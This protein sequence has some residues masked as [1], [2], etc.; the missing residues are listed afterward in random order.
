MSKLSK[1]NDTGKKRILSSIPF[2]K[3]L[4]KN[5]DNI[6]RAKKKNNEPNKN[7]SSLDKE[8]SSALEHLQEFVIGQDD[9]IKGVCRAF[10]RPF[11]IDNGKTYANLVFVFGPKGSGRYYA[12]KVIAV[13]LKNRRLLKTADIYNLDFSIYDSDEHTNKLLLP[14]LYKAFYGKP[15]VV[16]IND[17]DKACRKA[18]AY[19][20]SLVE[21]G[22][23]KV[24]KRF[25]WN[26]GD[27]QEVSGSY[28][29]GT[30]NALSA[31]GK[32]IFVLSEKSQDYLYQVFPKSFTSEIQD[33][34]H[35]N[36]LS[37]DYLEE[38]GD[39]FFCDLSE[40]LKANFEIV[41][42][43]RF[44]T[45]DILT[46]GII[47]N[48]AE[49]LND[50]INKKTYNAIGNM[51]LINQ[52]ERGSKLSLSIS[53]NKIY[54][55]GLYLIDIG[56]S[57]D[58]DAVNLAKEE[59]NKIIG[60]E[61]VKAFL[62]DIELQIR[63]DI[64]SGKN[65]EIS[66]H[67][68]FTGNPGTGKTS[69]ARIVAKWFKALGFLSSGHLIESS[70]SDFVGQY[71]GET[72]IK[73]L[74]VLKRAKG[75]ILFIDEAYSLSLGKGDSFG[76]EA[77]DT[78]VKYMEDNRDDL[79]IILAGYSK[80]MDEF[81]KI[82]SG[83]KSRF[84]YSIEFPDYSEEQL[85]RIA[86]IIAAEKGYFI[87]ARCEDALKHFFK[88]QKAVLKNEN[89][90]GRMARNTVEKA[91]VKRARRISKSGDPLD[92]Y[93]LLDD[94]EITDN[95]IDEQEVAAVKAELNQII[96]QKSIKEC[97]SKIEAQIRYEKNNNISSTTSKHM[98]FLGNPGTGKTTI[99]RIVAKY[100]N[101]LGFLSR[102]H[103]VEAD[104]SMLVGQ[105]IGETTQKTTAIL[106][107]AV[108]GVL[109]I[110]EAYSLTR[111]RTDSFGLEAIDTLVKFIE[112]FRNDLVVI[113]AG[114]TDEMD[115]FLSSNPGLKSR[116]IYSIHFENY[117][118]QELF[119]ITEKIVTE[120]GYIIDEAAKNDL[121]EYYEKQQEKNA[122]INGNGRMARN[123]SEKAIISYANR[124]M[125]DPKSEKAEKRILTREDFGIVKQNSHSDNFN[126][127][128][129]L[130]SVIGMQNAK[131]FIR[132]LYSLVKLNE[133]R[134]K[135]GL[136][137]DN[138]Q[139]LHMI[140]MGNPG[141]GKTTMARIVAKMFHSMGILDSDKVVETDRAGLIAGYVG[142]TAIKT[143]N[144]INS[145]L[146]GVLFI[147]EA[148]SLSNSVNTTD[149]GK[150]AIDTLVKDMDDNRDR[151]IVILAG[152]KDD[153]I[154][155]LKTNPGLVSR[156]PNI[157]EFKDYNDHELLQIAKIILNEKGYI[158]SKG[159]KEKLL[160]ICGKARIRKDFG[161]GRFVRNICELA[162]R[163]LSLRVSN[164]SELTRE[165]LS[166]IVEDD[167]EDNEIEV[168]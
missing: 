15:E 165:L 145:A 132:S 77:V 147:D 10:Q 154:A 111:G 90:N 124:M 102:G 25:N 32:F 1:N 64:S 13:L 76:I 51:V 153:M 80:E 33:V 14:D 144:V 62:E 3:R 130:S 167:I 155:F 39:S 143:K 166:T 110:D 96:G 70:R 122:K 40:K 53:S 125:N 115:V 12:L 121:I 6:D 116:F 21:S 86:S 17:F 43:S 20:V 44:K 87:E 65:S 59:L 29:I 114:Y 85:F 156:F 136:P 7:S 95:S 35:T 105:Y 38:I 127:E 139:A 138:S 128:I 83:L 24:D 49:S 160:L 56:K 58:E 63:L 117:S 88:R 104:R 52:I 36:A 54:A 133:S 82:N 161:N 9:Y 152:Y 89:G 94:F 162:I 168:K 126:L 27:L 5:D 67:M 119:Q 8:F 108:G 16:V 103:L 106:Q 137:S 142:Q 123:L 100:F 107:K 84:N 135:M 79:I 73:T 28:S 74:N 4:T 148:Y 48:G 112:D 134:K 41:I 159:A 93:L 157:I 61:E 46:D 47:R 11:L 91:I 31:N 60:L 69:I 72:A 66:K 57:L 50:I 146:D 45:R 71:V 131:D 129:E 68:I 75:G 101:A 99:A 34:I 26:R 98:I 118:G 42:A 164:Y 158:L 120:N 150:E 151:L 163:N 18:Q 19:I 113:I 92:K 55:N 141:T 22:T 140:F 37:I 78:I 30:M 109:F 81:M 23:V 2:F 97:L 149:F